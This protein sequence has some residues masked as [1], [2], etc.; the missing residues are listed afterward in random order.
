LTDNKNDL[1]SSFVVNADSKS[2]TFMTTR[3]LNTNDL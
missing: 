3:K 2:V 1:V